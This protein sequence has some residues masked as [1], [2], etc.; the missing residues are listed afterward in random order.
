M[1]DAFL[2]AARTS[3]M[4]IFAWHHVTQFTG[5]L[6]SEASHRAIVL[7]SPHIPWDLL[8]G[9]EDSVQRWAAATSTIQYTEEVARSVV[10]TLLQIASEIELLPHIPIG[11]WSWLLKRPS[12][13]PICLGRYAGTRG[14]VVRAVRAL[15]NIE[16]LKSYLLLV[17]SE[18][19]GF[20]Y[21][22]LDEIC[23]SIHENFGGIGMGFHRV[24]LVRRLDHILGELGRGSEYLKQHNPNPTGHDLEE[25][26][27]QYGILRE[28]L[29][30]VERRTSSLTVTPPL[31]TNFDENI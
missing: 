17:W 3:R 12:L 8:A 20:Q 5:T 29:L 6:L 28:V 31:H 15:G 11:V 10:D 27:H 7:T 1:L 26:K 25:M 14:Y 16:I 24:D 23:A 21:G 4:G 9:D 19:D 22:G 18:W 2:S 30:E 13:P